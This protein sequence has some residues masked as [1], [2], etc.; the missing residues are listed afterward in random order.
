MARLTL[1][2]RPNT[3][4]N[5]AQGASLVPTLSAETKAQLTPQELQEFERACQ[6]LVAMPNDLGWIFV[7]VGVLGIILPGVIGFPFVIIGGAVLLPGGRK[8]L[9]RQTVRRPGPVVRAFVRQMNRFMDD[10][11][12]DCSLPRDRSIGA[13]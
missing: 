7:S 8:W 2:P 9:S 12:R 6:R 13:G 4:D 10:L 11:E 5:S 1:I 3:G